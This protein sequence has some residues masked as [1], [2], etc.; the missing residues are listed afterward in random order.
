MK[1][2]QIG[3][4]SMGKRR[5]RCLK[6]L[7]FD[8]ILAFDLSSERRN[9]AKEKYGV[10]VIDSLK[11]IDFSEIGAM[12]IST[13]PDKHDEYIELA[14]KM[15]IPAFVEASVVLGKLEEL[16]KAASKAGVLIAPSCT[17][18]YHAGIKKIIEIAKGGKYG[19][20]SN[21]TYHSGQYLPDWHPYENVKDFYVSNKE[22]GAAREIVPFELA[23]LVDITGFPVG[24]KGFNGKTMDVGADIDD[25]YVIAMKFNNNIYGMLN[26]DVVS[27]YATRSFILNMEKAQI[28][29]RW[30]ENNIKLYDANT[31]NWS[32]IEYALGAAAEGY[33]KNIAEDMYVDE[34][35]AFIKAAEGE[36]KFPNTLEEDIAVLR[37]LEAAERLNEEK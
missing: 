23:W 29:W 14:I 6:K 12:I 32:V 33:N 13:P 11:K 1:F 2:L 27:R 19:K 3:L 24:V 20:V 8:D 26:V 28:L 4:G 34:L 35:S 22:T 31:K 36:G 7:G 9:E 30:D 5:I 25:T 10:T 37:V 18:R 21:F 16:E 15:K 17:L